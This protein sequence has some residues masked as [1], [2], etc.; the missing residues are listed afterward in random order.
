[1]RRLRKDAG[2]PNSRNSLSGTRQRLFHAIKG[3]RAGFHAAI[4]HCR[5]AGRFHL[6]R[7]RQSQNGAGMQRELALEL[8]DQG[9]KSCVMRPWRHFGEPDFVAAHKQLDTEYAQPAQSARDG[10][11]H[12]ARLHKSLVAHRLGLPGFDIVAVFLD[13]ADWL[14]EEGTVLGAHGELGDLEIELDFAFQNDARLPHP[15]GGK[16]FLPGRRQVCIRTQ[17][18]LALAGG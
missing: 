13:M 2:L 16:C 12:I 8:C 10:G 18:R 7:Y 15:P 4:D 14:A 6:R 5:G 17:P 11:G 1:M 3:E 9:H